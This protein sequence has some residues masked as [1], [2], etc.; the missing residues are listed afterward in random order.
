VP[1]AIEV[2]LEPDN[3]RQWS[4]GA[5]IGRVIVE[6]GR[7]LAAQGF[8]PDFIAPSTTCMAHAVIYFDQLIAI[9]D[10]KK[11]LKEIAYHRYCKVSAASLRAIAAR[12]QAHGLA[13]AM[14]E[15]WD[16]R[17][18]HQT[19]HEDLTLGRNS[20]WQQGIIAGN[21]PL[22]EAIAT[23]DT[24][25][26]TPVVTIGR[27]TRFASHY[28]KHVRLGAKRI[29]AESTAPALEPIAFV[30]VNGT[31]VVV[32]NALNT[33]SF[34]LNGLPEGTYGLW[35]TTGAESLSYADQT[36]KA[37]EMVTTRIPAA[38]VLTVYGKPSAPRRGP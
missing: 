9:T 26:A 28:Y 8:T 18:T 35:Y 13:T 20:A 29:G 1:D 31:Y 37:G 17:N 34:A 6:T 24:T 14:L 21:N 10:V 16:R 23:I 36:I 3:V 2:I 33:G 5:L 11:Y 27:I 4:S 12:A 30:N 32:V 7:K 22:D 25:P 38:G 19:L 15:W